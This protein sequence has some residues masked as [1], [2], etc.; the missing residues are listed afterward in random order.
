MS[1]VGAILRYLPYAAAAA[2]EISA[3]SESRMSMSRVGA[4]LRC[5]PYAA[6]VAISTI[7][8]IGSLGIGIGIGS[9]RVWDWAWTAVGVLAVSWLCS[10]LVKPTPWVVRIAARAAATKGG[11]LLVVVIVGCLYLWAVTAWFFPG[12]Q[13]QWVRSPF[14][15]TA[16]TAGLLFAT[17]IA[18]ALLSAPKQRPRLIRYFAQSR[19]TVKSQLA[20]VFGLIVS[21]SIAAWDQLLLLL[22]RHDVV[23]FYLARPKAGVGADPV[24]VTDL[25]NGNDV[26]RL[27]VWQLGDMVPTLKVNDVI[28]FEQPLF[29]SNAV[30][31]WLVL[32]FRAIVGLTLIGT[33]LAIV[34]AERSKLDNP[35]S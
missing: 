1:R 2:I 18:L 24:S 16:T 29:Y 33:V 3:S 5:L 11:W 6:A 10:Y 8:G 7:F 19:F 35:P 21:V 27:L 25:I 4:I 22:A 23:R 13:T 15:H 28:G 26:L 30:T 14:Q 12:V 9:L 31:G 34:Q 32:A 17:F 20:L